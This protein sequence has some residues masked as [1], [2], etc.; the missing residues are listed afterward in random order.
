ME[1]LKGKETLTEEQLLLLN[2]L[3][4]LE[5]VTIHGASDRSVGDIVKDLLKRNGAG[6]DNSR[7]D[8]EEEIGTINEYPA[9]ISRD[10]WIEILEA[11]QDDQQLL[12]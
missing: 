5:N 6:L 8:N 9:A 1:T 2:N 3:I 12:L 11:I 4:Y 7:T 10:Q